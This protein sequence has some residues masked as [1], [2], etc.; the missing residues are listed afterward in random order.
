VCV[1]DHTLSNTTYDFQQI[2]DLRKEEISWREIAKIYD[3]HHTNVMRW[4]LRERN[5]RLKGK[6][7]AIIIDKSKLAASTTLDHSKLGEDIQKTEVYLRNYGN[8]PITDYQSL[9][10]QWKW[11]D[12]YLG[13]RYNWDLM[14]LRRLDTFLNTT[15]R[16]FA[17]LP[18]T[19]GKTTNVIGDAL[20]WILEHREPY[21]MFTA[22]PGGKSRIFRAMRRLLK[23][24]PI[25]QAYGDV[26]EGNGNSQTGEIYFVDEIYNHAD[27]TFKVTTRMSDIIG[28]HPKRIHFE[29]IVQQPFSGSETKEKFINWYDEVVEYLA[30]EGTR[31]TGTG[32]RKA[33]DDVY[34]YIIQQN[35]EVLREKAIEKISGRYPTEADCTFDITTDKHGFTTK[36]ITDIDLS[37]GVF[38]YLECPN[39]SPKYLHSKRVL[40]LQAF[41][42]QMQNNPLPESGLYFDRDDWIEVDPYPLK[43]LNNYFITVDSGYGQS[44]KA[45]NTAILVLGIFNSECFIVDGFIGRIAFD[46]ILDKIEKFQQ[47]YEPM[48]TFVQTFF[49]EIWIKQRGAARGINMTNV[50]DKRNK[51]MR[52]DALKPWYNQHTIK[53]YKTLPCKQL[54][55]QEYIQYNRRDSTADRHDDGLDALATGLDKLTHYLV[56]TEGLRAYTGSQYQSDKRRFEGRL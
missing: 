49:A 6:S 23:S 7:H 25:R 4:Y 13:E 32:T 29:D 54:L 11:R 9:Y 27:P 56:R 43:H 47:L 22:G 18:R 46:V 55:F 36:Q 53:V 40:K 21:L 50:E 44:K 16:G 14:H 19:G 12:K 35:F 33:V 1:T 52:I 24:K 10:P 3:K 38:E 26:M 8:M 5:R 34:S 42:S 51:I 45:D 39:W 15:M 20:R 41:E 37:V 30:V 48:Q 2:T 28:S 31:L 17:F